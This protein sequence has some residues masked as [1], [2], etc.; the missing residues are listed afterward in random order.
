MIKAGLAGIKSRRRKLLWRLF[1]ALAACLLLTVQIGLAVHGASHLHLA[2]ETG[3]CR[4]C[5][6]NAH[7]VAEPP[8]ALDL[9]PARLVVV[10]FPEEAEAPADSTS[11]VPA[12]RGPPSVS[13]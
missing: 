11:Q 13:V 12:A 2:G 10:L 6:L 5:V 4:L 7:F 1:A 3:D 8:A 9:E